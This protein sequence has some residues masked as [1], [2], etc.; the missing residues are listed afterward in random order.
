MWFIFA[1]LLVVG[2]GALG[3]SAWVERLGKSG[4]VEPQAVDHAQTAIVLGAGVWAGGQLSA[5]LQDRVDCGIELFQAGHV[6]SLLM[7][8][9]HGYKDYDEVNAMR[10]Y[11]VAHG[12]P[13][14]KIFM[15]HAGF[16]TYDSM[17]RARQVFQVETAI[18]VTNRFHLARS[19]FLARKAGI[20]AQGVVADRQRYAEANWYEQREFMARCKAFLNCYILNPPPALGGR[21]VPITG[22]ARLS[23]DKD[24]HRK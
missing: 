8:G 21:P 4:I 6:D 18:V 20:K 2:V 1:G 15:D 13:N 16:N 12:V 17:A 14:E 3:A 22:D 10:E 11:A 24:L 7:S 23:H 5:V 19:V 9:D